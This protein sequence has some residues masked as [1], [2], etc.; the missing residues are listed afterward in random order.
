[1][2]MSTVSATCMDEV[3]GS[4]NFCQLIPFR[5]K[6]MP[7]AKLLEGMCDYL[8]WYAKDI[9]A[10]KFRHL[11]RFTEMTYEGR[12]RNV[13]FADGI[14][15]RLTGDEAKNFASLSADSKV[16]R[17][18]SQRAPSFSE[19]NVDW[20]QTVWLRAWHVHAASGN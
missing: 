11:Y 12:W 20:V 19:Q 13:E 10:V 1:M 18:V 5:K 15:R 14:R 8:L 4:G 7:L 2:K 6:L 3:F 16:Y 17:L 9:E